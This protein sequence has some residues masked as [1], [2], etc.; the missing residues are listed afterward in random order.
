M[1][2]GQL[3]RAAA[4]GG[5]AIVILLVVGVQAP[6]AIAWGGLVAVIDI[7]VGHARRSDAPP[8]LGLEV[9]DRDAGRRGDIR[10]FEWAVDDRTGELRA[11]ARIRAR[12]LVRGVLEARGVDPDDPDR[13][14]DIERLAGPAAPR[15]IDARP[16]TLVDLDEILRHI[17]H[18][19]RDAAASPTSSERELE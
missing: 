14:G 18:T 12:D 13:R 11:S 3:I 7:G 19:Q 16:L 10:A 8:P 9:P 15:L 2:P 5:G 1:T 17:E 4:L 6:F